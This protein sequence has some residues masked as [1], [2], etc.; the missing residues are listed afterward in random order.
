MPVVAWA[1]GTGFSVRPWWMFTLLMGSEA[2]QGDE[3]HGWITPGPPFDS[4]FLI[5][6]QAP[7]GEWIQPHDLTF[8][9]CA[10][11]VPCPRETNGLRTVEGRVTL[12]CDADEF[13]SFTCDTRTPREDYPFNLTG[14]SGAEMDGVGFTRVLYREG[15]G[16]GA[17]CGW[18]IELQNGSG[19]EG[20]MAIPAGQGMQPVELFHNPTHRIFAWTVDYPRAEGNVD[21]SWRLSVGGTGCDYSHIGPS[22]RSYDAT[23]SGDENGNISFQVKG[24]P[25]ASTMSWRVHSDAAPPRPVKVDLLTTKCQK[26]DYGSGVTYRAFGSFQWGTARRITTANGTYRSERFMRFSAYLP[27]DPDRSPPENY[28]WFTMGGTVFT[29]LLN[30][31]PQIDGW[32]SLLPDGVGFAFALDDNWL[33]NVGEDRQDWRCFI[34]DPRQEPGGRDST[35]ERFTVGPLDDP[36]Q[37]DGFTGGW[38]ATGC[39]VA[40]SNGVATVTVTSDNASISKT[41]DMRNPF[42]FLELDAKCTTGGTVSLQLGNRAYRTQDA[43]A[44]WKTLRW[45][46]CAPVGEPALFDDTDSIHVPA[47][48]Y[49]GPRRITTVTIAGLQAGRTYQFCNLTMPIVSGMKVFFPLIWREYIDADDIY[50]GEQWRVW[51]RLSVLTDRRHAIDLYYRMWR[52]DPPDPSHATDELLTLLQLAARVADY[53]QIPVTIGEYGGSSELQRFRFGA[54]D[55]GEIPAWFLRHVGYRYNSQLGFWDREFLADA[56]LS[57]D[58]FKT[59]L[60]ADVVDVYPGFGDGYDRTKPTPFRVTK[61][62]QMAVH[63]LVIDPNAGVAVEGNEVRIIRDGVQVDSQVSDQL[64]YYRTEPNKYVGPSLYVETD[65]TGGPIVVPNNRPSYGAAS[66]GGWYTNRK[67]RV[68]HVVGEEPSEPSGKHQS[69]DTHKSGLVTI[70]TADD[71]EIQL[72]VATNPQASTWKVVATGL[73]GETPCVK[74]ERP[75]PERC[76]RLAWQRNGYILTATTLNE[77]VTWSVP[78][79]IAAG[80]NPAI[81]TTPDGRVCYYW[82]DGAAIKGTIHD[83]QGNV[84]VS[85]FTAVA[86]GVDEDG[87]DAADR[88]LEYGSWRVELVYRSS[89]NLTKRSSLDGVVFT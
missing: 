88:M 84:V 8:A 61:Q 1:A 3:L 52:Q 12:W 50:S 74:V 87:I 49:A 26:P 60:R 4:Y 25:T 76:I 19:S 11:F 20:E 14:Q 28:Y 23:F 62:L 71:G 21:S 15:P 6:L 80:E 79:T 63:G 53:P 75:G 2:Q 66:T 13:M 22:N 72:R 58:A 69:I 51:R 56:P 59:M 10:A 32:T 24:P 7:N 37:L 82:R 36:W 30:G 67:R 44:T 73:I 17:K 68:M 57:Q 70:A 85:P 64:G 89:G 33:R 29:S 83:A 42:R 78:V 39:S 86:S 48:P 47:G 38:A 45:D 43:T 55:F 81:V 9:K 16:E 65:A 27:N 46:L 34:D 40:Y 18:K 54:S 35:W 31:W 77:G 5:Q 41:W